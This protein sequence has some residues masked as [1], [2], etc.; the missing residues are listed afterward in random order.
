M[1]PLLPA[2]DVPLRRKISFV[3]FRPKIYADPKFKLESLPEEKSEE[4]TLSGKMKI[5]GV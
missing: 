3:P 2:E 4:K 1:T 5:S